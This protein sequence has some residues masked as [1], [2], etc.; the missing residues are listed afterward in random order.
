MDLNQ[1]ARYST[2]L[3][4]WNFGSLV[5]EVRLRKFLLNGG[6]RGG[7]R[8]PRPTKP[9]RGPKQSTEEEKEDQRQKAQQRRSNRIAARTEAEKETQRRQKDRERYNAKSTA[10]KKRKLNA[11]TRTRRAKRRKLTHAR[12]HEALKYRH[13]NHTS[14]E[15]DESRFPAHN[16]GKMNYKCKECGALMYF[17]ERLKK[18]KVADP[19]FGLC[20]DNGKVKLELPTIPPKLDEYLSTNT[21]E[22]KYFRKYIR[23]LN[24]A[25]SFTS[26]G[27]D[28]VQFHGAPGCYKVQGQIHH[29]IGTH[30]GPTKE[31]RRSTNV[32]SPKY[33][34]IYFYDTDHELDN[35]MDFGLYPDTPTGRRVVANLQEIMRTM[36]PLVKKFKTAIQRSME[37]DIPEMQI[38]IKADMNPTRS[39][40]G[41][42]SISRNFCNTLS[43]FLGRYNRPTVAQ[44]AAVVPGA[45]SDGET[46]TTRDIVLYC[47]DNPSI[48][49][50]DEA[51][52]YG[53]TRIDERHPSYDALQY[54][55][56]FPDGSLGW[57]PLAY[58][59]NKLSAS[60]KKRRAKRHQETTA[61][62]QASTSVTHE[63]ADDTDATPPPTC[64]IAPETDEEKLDDVE[65]DERRDDGKEPDPEPVTKKPHR[66]RSD[67][68]EAD[69]TSSD[70]AGAESTVDVS[71]DTAGSATASA[72]EVD[73]ESEAQSMDVDNRSIA[74]EPQYSCN[75]CLTLSFMSQ[76]KLFSPVHYKQLW[77]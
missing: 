62:V 65:E 24:A 6:G 68:R 10:A 18:S 59:Y 34:S 61:R 58:H 5:L 17:G 55:L 37:E 70:E 11:R 38:V 36:S 35:R 71:M 7:K 46:A 42:S 25:F 39:H 50:R 49:K 3:F 53:L 75:V 29:R 41:I 48:P 44:I 66:K 76:T 32:Y 28:A 64:I 57:A 22:A 54:P 26:M 51:N 13:C 14:P 69:D 9:K 67:K 33:A 40:K 21:A 63:S 1:L 73:A 43:L 19:E 56:L 47:Q 15:F 60:Q 45:D 2:K 31:E 30:F 27:C 4:D 52:Y 20:C 23:K 72:S 77:L 8:F 16:V 12:Q 74:S